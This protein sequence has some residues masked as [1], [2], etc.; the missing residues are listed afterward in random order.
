MEH[1]I[2]KVGQNA[3]TAIQI[4]W[5]GVRGNREPLDSSSVMLSYT[6]LKE[7][8]SYNK[9]VYDG[10]LVSVSD[11][12][13]DVNN[14]I[15]YI[16]YSNIGN[17]NYS[18]IAN[19]ISLKSFSDLLEYNMI[20]N[21]KVVSLFNNFLQNNICKNE[22]LISRAVNYL[23]TYINSRSDLVQAELQ[24]NESILT[25]YLTYIFVN[26]DDTNNNMV[27]LNNRVTN[28]VNNINNSI[29]QLRNDHNNDL[30]DINTKINNLDNKLNRVISQLNSWENEIRSIIENL[31]GGN[32]STYV[33]D[34]NFGTAFNPS[35]INLST[36]SE[37][38]S[39]NNT[40]EN[41][42]SWEYNF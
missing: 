5:V 14:G 35:T 2:S 30:N 19:K 3:K 27:N 42:L 8:I 34:Y 33:P 37:T 25:D 39:Y 4:N 32:G 6:E 41:N 38:N 26:L 22:E 24:R 7:Y 31:H 36:N 11:L 18:Y 13:N 10:Q 40:Y 16:S 23:Y 29:N 17:D 12:E 20:N 1:N 9:S 28:E 15:Y 21:E